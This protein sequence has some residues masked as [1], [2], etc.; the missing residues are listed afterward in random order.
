MTKEQ[1]LDEFWNSFGIDF[2]DEN[3][4]QHANLPTS[5][6]KGSTWTIN[7]DLTRQIPTF[8]SYRQLQFVTSIAL[9]WPFIGIFSDGLNLYYDPAVNPVCSLTPVDP[10]DPAA[11][12]KTV[13]SRDEYRTIRILG[14]SDAESTA[15]K[16]WLEANAT[17]VSAGSVYPY[18]TY[19]VATDSLNDYGTALTASLWYHGTSWGEAT[20]KCNQISEII[21]R[22][23]VKV[24]YT[25]GQLWIK[26]GSPFAQRM[27]DPNDDLIRRIVLN[28]EAE[29]LSAD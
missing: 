1:A 24:D 14:G 7:E 18:G 21:G 20:E 3:S 4:V 28:V 26:R 27:S 15:L 25:G 23:G 16:S 19:S 2:F 6:L 22:G 11:G 17:L 29:F 8:G 5:L 12:M 9:P 10:D 13:W